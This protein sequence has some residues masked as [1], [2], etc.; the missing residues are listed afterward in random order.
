MA[1]SGAD[2]GVGWLVA[3]RW[4]GV[5][6][7][8]GDAAYSAA[9]KSAKRVSA[10]SSP[11]GVR[12]AN[13]RVIAM[14]TAEAMSSEPRPLPPAPASTASAQPANAVDEPRHWSGL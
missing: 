7:I 2:S 3:V 12:S 14:P 9:M 6:Q 5:I 4:P 1:T 13:G 10:S 8:S 11:S